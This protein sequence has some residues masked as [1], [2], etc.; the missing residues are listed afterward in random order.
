MV[1]TESNVPEIPDMLDVRH[2]AC[3]TTRALARSHAAK[4]TMF[5]HGF[6]FSYRRYA[7]WPY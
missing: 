2:S 7:Y 4:P 6:A 5:G 1:P 3:S